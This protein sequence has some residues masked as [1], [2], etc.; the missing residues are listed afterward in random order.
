M[1][2]TLPL[3]EIVRAH[4]LVEDRATAGRVVLEL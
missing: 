2:A 4:E 1:A 3:T